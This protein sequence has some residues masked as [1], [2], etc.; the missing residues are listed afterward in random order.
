MFFACFIRSCSWLNECT[1]CTFVVNSSGGL[2]VPVAAAAA[3]L[4]PV[5]GWQAARMARGAF[6]DPARWES[7]AFW[8]V[9]LLIATSSAELVGA[10]VV[11]RS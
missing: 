4:S 11:L 3:L 7:L 1:L 10:L 8:S 5:A 6:R 9:A 2:P